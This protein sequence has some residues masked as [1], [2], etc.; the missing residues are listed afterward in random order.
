MTAALLLCS[1]FFPLFKELLAFQK[2]HVILSFV[3]KRSLQECVEERKIF[4]TAV[5]NVNDFIHFKLGV[6]TLF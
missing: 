2:C 6:A 3:I 1:L 4:S 5:K